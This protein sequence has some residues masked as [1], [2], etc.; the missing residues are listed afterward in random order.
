MKNASEYARRVRRLLGQI[1]A[2]AEKV[3][4]LPPGDVTDQVLVAVLMRYAPDPVALAA[5]KRLR[6]RTVDLNELRV[7]PV[8]ELIDLLG[9]AFPQNKVAAESVARVLG[10]IF[11]RCHHLD[12]GFLRE[13]SRKDARTYLDTLDG[14]DPFSSALVA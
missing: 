2:R 7:T 6:E 12:L 1:K 9:P 10:A 14:M 3:A 13:M 4:E 11:N 5:Y 8:A